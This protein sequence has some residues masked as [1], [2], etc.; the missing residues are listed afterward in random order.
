MTETADFR[1]LTGLSTLLKGS[2]A[3]Y[4]GIA[5]IGLWSGWLEIE[6]LHRAANGAAVSEAE[7]VASDSRQALL[8]GLYFVIFLVT[9]VIFLRWTYLANRN[10]HSLAATDLDFTPGWAVGWYFIPIATLWKPYQ[11]LKETF[12]ASHPDYGEDWRRAP[13]PGLLPLW[14]T[15]W[16][17]STFVGQ[18]VFRAALRANSVDELLASSWLTFVSDALDLPLSI[19][20]ILLV[21]KLQEW[22]LAKHQH[23]ASTAS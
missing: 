18:A 23:V 22:Q 12:K 3:V 16:I 8:G 11:A 2:L 21:S 13:H 7:A 15:L 20:V 4:M 10:A 9:G 17:L 14:W 6:L 1:K 19:V 5:A